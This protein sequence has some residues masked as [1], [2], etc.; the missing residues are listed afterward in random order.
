MT[1]KLGVLGEATNT[2][3]GTY[4]VYTV[5][6]SKGAK[7]KFMFRFQGGV[8]SVIAIL[9]NGEEV[10]RTGAMTTGHYWFTTATAGAIG[11]A[12]AAAAPDGTTA[13]LTNS[14]SGATFF[15]SQGDLVQYQVITQALLAALCQF[16]GIEVDS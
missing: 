2:A 8:S 5:P 15:V 7:G 16:V 6:T 13:A 4:T 11:P 1:D 14:P 10:A 3:V 9:V 12:T